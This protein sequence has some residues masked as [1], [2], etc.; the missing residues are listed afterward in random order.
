MILPLTLLAYYYNFQASCFKGS[1]RKR[2][3][4]LN[5]TENTHDAVADDEK[6]KMASDFSRSLKFLKKIKFII[7]KE[8]SNERECSTKSD[9][10]KNFSLF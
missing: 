2:F 8:V 9:V 6:E 10:I 5:S 7:F 1:Q 3:L 4:S